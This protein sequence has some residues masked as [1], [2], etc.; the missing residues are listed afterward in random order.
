MLHLWERAVVLEGAGTPQ[1]MQ[2]FFGELVCFSI[3]PVRRQMLRQA[4]GGGG[5][6]SISGFGKQGTKLYVGRDQN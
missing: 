1:S 5:G 6:I 2:W 4:G 3:E